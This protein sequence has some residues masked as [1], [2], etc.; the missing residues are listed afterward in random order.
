M[1]LHAIVDVSVALAAGWTPTDLAAA[2]LSGGAR[3][4]QVRA[5][6][7]SGSA[8]LDVAAAVHDLARSAGALVIVNDRADIAKLASAEGVHLGQDD[9][10]P[11]AARLLIGP[12]SIVGLSTHTDEQVARAMTEPISYI[13]IGPVFATSTKVTGYSPVGLEGVRRAAAAG[14]AQGLD[15]VAIGGVTLQNVVDVMSAGASG[16]AVISDLLE[17]GNPEAR[18]RAYLARITGAGGV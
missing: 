12:G 16:V 4:I 5:K 8:F 2:Y 13:A 18:T 14:R 7:A 17:G 1:R 11:S 10:S 6:A 15:L 3:L 9:L